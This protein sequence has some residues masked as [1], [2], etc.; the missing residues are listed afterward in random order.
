MEVESKGEAWH[1]RYL[2]L[3]VSLH[4]V[5][6]EL[7]SATGLSRVVFDFPSGIMGLKKAMLP[8]FMIAYIATLLEAK[9]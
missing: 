8:P 6:A 4:Q 3:E 2:D 9:R 5:Q 7:S 1:R